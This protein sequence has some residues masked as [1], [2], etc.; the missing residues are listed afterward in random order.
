[1]RRGFKRALLSILALLATVFATAQPA[2]AQVTPTCAG[3]VATIVGNGATINGTPGDDVIVGTAAANTINA[4]AGN[5]VVCGGGGGDIIF[6]GPG[7]DLLFGENGPDQMWGNAGNDLLRGGPGN[8][9]L[10]AGFGRDVVFGGPNADLIAGGPGADLLRG[11]TGNDTVSGGNGPDIVEGGRGNDIVRGGGG[12]DFVRG[13]NG[14]D[15]LTGGSGRGDRLN[16]GGGTD[17]CRDRGFNTRFTA[18]ES[19]FALTIL[20]M[21]DTHS[22]LNPD[23][24][25]LILG[26]AETRVSQGGAA[27]AVAKIKELEAANDNV[28][29][30]HAGDAVTGTLFYSLFKGEADAALMNEAC[31]DIYELG[32]HE[33]D[34]G[35]QGAA[36][37]IGFV[38][39]TETCETEVL[40]ANVV[41]ALGTPLNPAGTPL[42]KPFV[43]KEYGDDMVG[44]IGLDIAGKTM[45]SSSPLETTE[46]LDEVE[47]AQRFID[48]LLEDGVNKIVLVTHTQLANDITFAG[49]LT[50]VDVIVGGDSHSLLGNFAPLGLNTMGR[51]PYRTAD[52]TGSPVC[53][54]HAWQYSW[55]V[56]QLNVNFDADGV[57]TS[58]DGTPHL[59]LE[60]SFKRRPADGGDRV[61][62]EGP[63]RQ[64][65][66][67]DIA[68]TPELSIVTPDAA[69][70]TVL[71]GFSAQVAL[72]E[73]EV[74]GSSTDTL[75]LERIPGQGRSQICDVSDTAIMGGDIQQLVTDAFRV[76]AF[77]SDFALQ[78]A[79]GVRIDIPAGD[80]T[81]AD[82]FE[83][84]P[85]ANTIVN[86]EMSGAEI[87]A[88]LEEAITFALDPDGSTGAY[89][90]ASGLRFDVD[91][92]AAE[93][94]RVSNMEMRPSGTEAWVPFVTEGTYTVATNSFIA[95]GRDGYITFGTVTDDGRSSDTLLDYAQSFIDYVEQDAAGVIAKLA[96]SEYSTQSFVPLA[97]PA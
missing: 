93:G 3:Q 40:A 18:C 32:N 11:G 20:H 87:K 64:A 50:G 5:D 74:I 70:Q 90:Y 73:L 92:N 9:L 47:T 71:E 8:D 15:D 13:N 27:N 16:G 52:A 45:N 42:F 83:L 19:D 63:D 44:F 7:R 14:D 60:D 79:G 37:M 1:M 39:D 2:A 29:K 59:I 57:V 67:D 22:H 69:A 17:V 97:E 46:F 53:I 51:Y 84:L 62:L 25:D 82:A 80:I 72:L 12:N 78:N 6:G 95:A 36:D 96:P 21:N 77:E 88:V 91:M 31:F 89:P 10:L 61:E 30:V 56:G 76:R 28:V 86:L 38:K 68:A 65:V 41:P 24:G 54:V 66:I 49:M 94:S 43:V 26:G 48:G 4:G 81:I 34:D 58:C 35:D 55:I 33:F 85:F 75:C 23:S